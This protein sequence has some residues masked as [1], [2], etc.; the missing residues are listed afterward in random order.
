M[1]QIV[2][3]NERMTVLIGEI[4]NASKEQSLGLS[5]I[6]QAITL[7]DDTTHQ[8]VVLVE[9]TNQADSV[10]RTQAETVPHFPNATSIRRL[11]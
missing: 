5:Q 11:S 7:M 4:A 6:N 2:T 9:Q 1:Q 3:T 8:N 10:L